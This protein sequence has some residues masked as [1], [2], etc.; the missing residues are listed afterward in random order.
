AGG[1]RGRR[2][3][4]AAFLLAAFG[5]SL[6]GLLT[7]RDQGLYAPLDQDVRVPSDLSPLLETLHAHHVDRVFA[8]YWL[9][10]RLSFETDEHIIATPNRGE[11][12]FVASHGRLLPVGTGP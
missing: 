6:A 8:D 4:S 2:F 5:L 3:R 11:T 1:A 10:Y 9:A 7:M 12:G